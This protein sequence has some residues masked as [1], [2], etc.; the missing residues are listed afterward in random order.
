MTDEP[1]NDQQTTSDA[2]WSALTS[3]QRRVAGVLVEKAKTTPSAYPLTLNGI[4]TAA[5][6]KSNR[7][8]VT[9][10]T[11]EQVENTLYELR[12][13]GAVVEVQS[14]GRVPKFRHQLYEWM[15][16]DKVELAVMAELLLRGE[17][18]LGDL[19]ARASRM[20]KID[21]LTELKPIVQSLIDKQ[22]MIELT[23]AG[24]GQIVSHNL[25][26][27]DELQRLKRDV[28]A[29]AGFSGSSESSGSENIRARTSDDTSSTDPLELRISRLEQAVAEMERAITQLKGSQQ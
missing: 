28:E 3:I 19:R 5:N 1:T 13:L 8:P 6:Q 20:N 4:V 12:K 16:V 11:E 24:R 23:P 9:N 25:Y 22:L 7:S 26:Q 2:A 21:G 29:A 14:S 27:S 17:Q 18:T 15:G 10:L